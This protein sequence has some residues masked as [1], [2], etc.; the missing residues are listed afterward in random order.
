ML[1]TASPASDVDNF[2]FNLRIW[3]VRMNRDVQPVSEA[4]NP[5]GMCRMTKDT[6]GK[7]KCSAFITA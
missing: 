1:L 4:Q 2:V 3:I 7:M 5:E 6:Q